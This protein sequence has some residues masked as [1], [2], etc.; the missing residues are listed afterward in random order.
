VISFLVYFSVV[1]TIISYDIYVPNL[2]LMRHFFGV[3]TKAMQMT[4]MISPLVGSFSGVLYGYFS[5]R[6]GR[7]LPMLTSLAF[8]GAGSLICALSPNIEIFI[9]GRI[10]QAIGSGGILNIALT[11]LGDMYQG[12]RYAKAIAVISMI[13]PVTFAFAPN[14]GAHL[15]KHFGFPSNFYFVLFLVIFLI[16]LFHFNVKETLQVKSSNTLGAIIPKLKSFIKFDDFMVLSLIHSLPIAVPMIFVTT[17][18]LLFVEEF[19]ITPTTFA[20]LQLIPIFFSFMTTVAYKNVIGKIGFDN[21]LKYGTTVMTMFTVLVIIC[22]IFKIQFIW[23][24][25][26]VHS[27]F[28]LGMSFIGTTAATKAFELAAEDK[29]LRIAFVS[30]VRNV[31]IAL[32]ILMAS[33][34]YNQ[35]AIP[36]YCLAAVMSALVVWLYYH[37]RGKCK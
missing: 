10:V 32:A 22:A 20:E 25:L 24:I 23:T 36:L 13:F 5:D 3:S 35:T 7:K 6:Y 9:L 19:C 29:G 17:N 12:V 31:V 26:A 28:F 34:L 16:P 27:F 18:S 30:I 33:F 4:I 2:S 21:A 11:I 37:H 8:L 1:V 15:G 14:I